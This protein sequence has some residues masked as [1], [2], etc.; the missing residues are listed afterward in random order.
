VPGNRARRAKQ[1]VCVDALSRQLHDVDIVAPAGAGD[2]AFED[3]DPFLGDRGLGRVAEKNDRLTENPFNRDHAGCGDDRIAG[4][5]IPDGGASPRADCCLDPH[6]EPRVRR[7]LTDLL[8]GDAPR[9]EHNT[10]SDLNGG[11]VAHYV[12]DMLCGAVDADG[13]CVGVLRGP[14]RTVGGEEDAA[15]ED[16]ARSVLGA[17]QSIEE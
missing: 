15:L 8:H 10:V 11:D 14:P 2:P 12:G 7:L 6:A 1:L 13:V 9:V 3:G 17:R 4:G 16:E 5:D